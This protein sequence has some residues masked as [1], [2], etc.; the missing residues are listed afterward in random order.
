MTNITENAQ[1]AQGVA[2][3]NAE[4][5]SVKTN[6]VA[7][8]ET[9]VQTEEKA[10]ETQT[11]SAID[12]MLQKHSEL[13]TESTVSPRD[14]VDWFVPSDD[15]SSVNAVYSGIADING[16]FQI[17]FEVFDS[18]T[19]VRLPDDLGAFVGGRQTPSQSFGSCKRL[20]NILKEVGG[21]Y[22]EKLSQLFDIAYSTYMVADDYVDQKGL[23]F[24]RD[25]KDN[26]GNKITRKLVWTMDKRKAMQSVI[27]DFVTFIS[28]KGVEHPE[29]PMV[30]DKR[31][32]EGYSAIISE[33]E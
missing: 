21:Y 26:Y 22:D 10:V 31:S 24:D 8:A 28:S 20:I 2:D 7:N 16:R 27:N 5:N 6:E 14:I 12:A 25:E 11:V 15:G 9:T 13:I 18:N 23:I 4:N 3:A 33:I 1:V 30:L 17:L 32:R 19:Y 29:I